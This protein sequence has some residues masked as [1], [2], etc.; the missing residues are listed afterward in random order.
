MRPCVSQTAPRNSSG[1]CPSGSGKRYHPQFDIVFALS[2]KVCNP[3]IS[4]PKAN[5][6]LP[7]C[8]G[9]GEVAV[10][11]LG[12]VP[13]DDRPAVDS[14]RSGGLPRQERTKG[15]KAHR[16]RGTARAEGKD[17]VLHS[18][19]RV[20]ARIAGFGRIRL[21]QTESR[22]GGVS[23]IPKLFDIFRIPVPEF[24]FR[25]VNF[26]SGG[27]ATPSTGRAPR[28]PE[29]AANTEPDR[30]GGT[31]GARTRRSPEPTE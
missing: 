29:R 26:D 25:T 2:E 16:G 19:F 27:T 10:P 13:R 17:A 18:V 7:T 15:E 4:N 28:T 14:P 11:D 21:R 23:I 6:P 12:I 20:A 1:V 22:P 31:T 24:D 5:S 30:S 3:L 9:P 8:V